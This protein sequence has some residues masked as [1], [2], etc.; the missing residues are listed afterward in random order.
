MRSFPRSDSRSGDRRDDEN[1]YNAVHAQYLYHG[2]SKAMKM[3]YADLS[4]VIKN[5]KAHPTQ[6]NIDYINFLSAAVEELSKLSFSHK[7]ITQAASFRHAC[8]QLFN[9]DF[10]I[11][12]SDMQKT[13]YGQVVSRLYNALYVFNPTDQSSNDSVDFSDDGIVFHVVDG[14]VRLLECVDAAT[15]KLASLREHFTRKKEL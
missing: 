11:F 4:R 7:E 3:I 12:E 5:S 13:P 1:L 10:D 15:E 8:C 2:P 14:V 6:E 9:N